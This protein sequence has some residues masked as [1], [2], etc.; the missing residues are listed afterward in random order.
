MGIEHQD[1]DLSVFYLILFKYLMKDKL[2]KYHLN[3]I[4]LVHQL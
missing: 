4:N 2:K 1:M 3:S